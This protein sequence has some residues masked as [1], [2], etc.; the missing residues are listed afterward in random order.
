[1]NRESVIQSTQERGLAGSMF[2]GMEDPPRHGDGEQGRSEGDHLVENEDIPDDR[3]H[4]LPKTQK[5]H[6]G[7][8]DSDR[9]PLHQPE[10]SSGSL[11]LLCR[12]TAGK[13]LLEHARVQGRQQKQ[14]DRPRRDQTDTHERRHLPADRKIRARKQ[15]DGD[16]DDEQDLQTGISPVPVVADLPDVRIHPLRKHRI[17]ESGAP[18]LGRVRIAVQS[19]RRNVPRSTTIPPC[20]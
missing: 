16:E 13:T 1:M 17:N 10:T 12:F 8:D 2:K 6:A 18:G 20:R 9:E 3:L 5:K 7:D 4:R 19:G 15:H 11:E 14:Q